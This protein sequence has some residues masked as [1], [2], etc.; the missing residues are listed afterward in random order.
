MTQNFYMQKTCVAMEFH[1]LTSNTSGCLV[2]IYDYA[3]DVS[4]ILFCA[5]IR[6]ENPS[7]YLLVVAPGPLV[8]DTGGTE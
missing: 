8:T 4:N 6:A 2:R 5:A 3:D 1:R 7:L